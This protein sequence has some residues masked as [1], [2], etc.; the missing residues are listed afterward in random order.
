MCKCFRCEMLMT[1][2]PIKV[3]DFKSNSPFADGIYHWEDG[4][5]CIYNGSESLAVENLPKHGCRCTGV[6]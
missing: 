4:F 6:E 5:K 3:V 2:E 1:D